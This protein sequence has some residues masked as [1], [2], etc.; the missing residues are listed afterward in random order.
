MDEAAVSV[1][2]AGTFPQADPGDEKL[3]PLHT[4]V[5]IVTFLHA[6]GIALWAL[7]FLS[8]SKRTSFCAE[9]RLIRLLSTKQ[10]I[11]KP[12]TVVLTKCLVDVRSF[13]FVLCVD[14]TGSSRRLKPM[15]PAADPRRESTPPEESKKEK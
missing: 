8:S 3:K 12:S 11:K 7:V 14:N 10:L 13:F 5:L 4:I 15:G 1:P 2:E 9:D 6:L